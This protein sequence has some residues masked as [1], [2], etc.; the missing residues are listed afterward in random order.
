MSGFSLEVEIVFEF[1][2]VSRTDFMPRWYIA[3]SGLNPKIIASTIDIKSFVG[4]FTEANQYKR[5][6]YDVYSPLTPEKRFQR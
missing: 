1:W 4:D 6:E 2:I 5:Y 3:A